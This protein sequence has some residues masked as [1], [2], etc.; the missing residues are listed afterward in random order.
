[1]QGTKTNCE[2]LLPTTN[3]GPVNRNRRNITQSQKGRE[4]LKR[5]CITGITGQDGVRCETLDAGNT[6]IV[7]AFWDY[8][9]QFF[10]VLYT[11]GVTHSSLL[12]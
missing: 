10:S 8:F 1:L 9:Q 3:D 4:S 6:Y 2:E 11:C 7:D 12:A 5:A